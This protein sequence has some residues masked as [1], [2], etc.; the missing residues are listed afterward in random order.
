MPVESLDQSPLTT[1]PLLEGA[2]G[3]DRGQI[4]GV[5]SKYNPIHS[6]TMSLESLDEFVVPAVP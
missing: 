6:A 2:V 5:A 1:V 3:A 4:A